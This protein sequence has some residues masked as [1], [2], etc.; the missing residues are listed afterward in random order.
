[1]LTIFILYEE[2]LSMLRQLASILILP[3]NAIVVIPVSCISYATKS[4]RGSFLA[5]C[6]G[7]LPGQLVYC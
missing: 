1:M 7:W 5:R 3:F 4:N 6:C 2:Y